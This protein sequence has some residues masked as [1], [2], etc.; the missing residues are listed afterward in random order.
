VHGGLVDP[1]AVKAQCNFTD[2]PT[3]AKH[4]QRSTKETTVHLVIALFVG[5][6]PWLNEERTIQQEPDGDRVEAE[7]RKLRIR[8]TL[9]SE[10]DITE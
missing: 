9:K 5:L 1:E 3:E 7:S 8:S 10:R 2:I 4:E 6:W